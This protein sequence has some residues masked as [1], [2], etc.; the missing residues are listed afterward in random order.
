LFCVAFAI[1]LH[2]PHAVHN[3]GYRAAVVASDRRAA[4]LVFLNASVL[5]A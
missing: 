2:E 1:K 5:I 3:G 4:R